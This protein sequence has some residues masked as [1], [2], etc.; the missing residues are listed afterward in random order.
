MYP[1]GFDAIQLTGRRLKNS[2]LEI[3]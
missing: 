1:I 2:L 3:V